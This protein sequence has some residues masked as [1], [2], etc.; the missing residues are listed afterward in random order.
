[1]VTNEGN[2][3]LRRSDS[4]RWSSADAESQLQDTLDFTQSRDSNIGR[5][6]Q[7]SGNLSKPPLSPEGDYVILS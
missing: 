6:W 5:Y 7:N 4:F 1:M 2:S 3:K